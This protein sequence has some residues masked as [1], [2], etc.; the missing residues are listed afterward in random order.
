LGHPACI[1][2]FGVA[3]AE[4]VVGVAVKSP[5]KPEYGKTKVRVAVERLSAV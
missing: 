3:G 4:H 5:C 1:S 2:D